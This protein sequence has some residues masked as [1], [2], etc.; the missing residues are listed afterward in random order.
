MGKRGWI[1]TPE[2]LKQTAAENM[3]ISSKGTYR[4][5]MNS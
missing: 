2:Q 3:D 5:L 4:N 1:K